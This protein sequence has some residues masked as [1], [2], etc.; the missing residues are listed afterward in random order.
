MFICLNAYMIL[1]EGKTLAQKIRDEIKEEIKKTGFHP[2]LAV[3]LVGDDPASK[4]YIRIKE[5]AC[6]EVGI[7][8]HKYIFPADCPEKQILETINFLNQD[9]DIHGIIIQLPLPKKFNTNKIIKVVIPEKDVDGFHPLNLTKLA[10]GKPRIIPPTAQAVL[11][12]LELTKENLNNKKIIILAKSEIFAKPIKYILEQRGLK[13]K[14][15]L[16]KEKKWSKKIIKA[17]VLIVALGQPNLIKKEMIGQNTIIIDVGTNY[18]KDKLFGDVDFE[19]VKN[20]ASW[21][22]P[23]PGG[24]GPLTVA[25][26]LKNLIQLAKY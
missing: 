25:F 5:K 23:V 16:F 6:H 12:L 26:L 9:K 18:I 1:L 17:D 19:D 14:L 7:Y 22:T 21:I 4:N 20:K 15:I 2:G 3:I 13:V 8:F 10:S 24:V 11:A